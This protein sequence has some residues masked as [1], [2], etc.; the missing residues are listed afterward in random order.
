MCIR[1]SHISFSHTLCVVEIWREAFLCRMGLQSLR[2]AQNMPQAVPRAAAVDNHTSETTTSVKHCFFLAFY[3]S[4]LNQKSIIFFL[5]FISIHDTKWKV[6]AQ[7]F[8]LG[9][10][11]GWAVLIWYFILAILPQRIHKLFFMPTFFNSL[12]RI[13][14][15]FFVPFGVSWAF[16]TL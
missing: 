14:G 6:R 5:H 8:I 11:V 12:Y 15:P 2:S 3:T 9:I 13:S 10:I 16:F 1:D 7:F 4:A